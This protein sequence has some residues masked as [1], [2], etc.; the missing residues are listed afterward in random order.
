MDRRR[1]PTTQQVTEMNKRK[2]NMKN[3]SLITL[4]AAFVLLVG[5]GSAIA[6]CPA[7]A[8]ASTPTGMK[9]KSSSYESNQIGPQIE[10]IEVKKG[11]TMQRRI[12]YVE[13]DA[14]IRKNY[15]EMRGMRALMS[16]H[17]PGPV[18]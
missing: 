8:K 12:A 14:V 5:A 2:L 4:T 16:Q 3:G 7:P 11:T 13:D 9:M 17:I 10:V 15:S 6:S 18:S 1:P